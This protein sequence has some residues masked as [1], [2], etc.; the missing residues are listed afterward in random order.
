M[1]SPRY[2][3]EISHPGLKKFKRIT[4]P[5]P[6]AVERQAHMEYARWEETWA[7]QQV[8][9]RKKADAEHARASVRQ[10]REAERA[11]K[12]ARKQEAEDA[13]EAA[14][15][16]RQVIEGILQHTLAIDDRVDF[17]S[18]KDRAPFAQHPPI[19]PAAIPVS[20]APQIEYR[21][22][23]P[24]PLSAFA[25]VVEFLSPKTRLRRESLEQAAAASLRA[26]DEQIY[27]SALA[28]WQQMADG[29]SRENAKRKASFDSARA[30]HETRR[31][32][33]IANQEET[34]RQVDALRVAYHALD[35]GAVEQYCDLVLSASVYPDEFPKT[36]ILRYA[37]DAR[38]LVVE[39]Q[40]PPPEALPA[41]K[42]V[43]Y[44]VSSDTF[45]EANISSAESRK[46]YDGAVYQ[47]I[48]RT[49]HELFEA[50]VV[51]AL[52]AIAL[53][54]V[55]ETI[56]RSTGRE[57]RPCI[58]TIH[59]QRNEFLA[60]N[61]AE[62]NP[63]ACFRKLKGVGSA[64]LVELAP[65]APLVHLPRDDARYIE[66]REV[67]AGVNGGSNL[68]AMNWEDFEH[69]VRELF[70]REFASAGAEVR[71]T[72]AS[73]DGGVDAV[74]LD[75]DPIRGGKFVIQAK[76]YTNLVPVAAV[77]ELWGTMS[78][79]RA[80]KGILVTTATFGPDAY[81][82]AKDKPMTLLDG[83]NLLYLLEKHGTRAFIDLKAAKALAS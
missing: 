65:V 69:L 72:R 23:V 33:Y 38:T 30:A 31:G 66:A 18:L 4:G 82:F 68:A 61:L 32:Q 24:S 20:A 16:A 83:S 10:A 29:V 6:S 48:L 5:H 59:V 9:A 28:T 63:K 14:K 11:Y 64:E 41:L 70:E 77:R 39:Y 50:D 7:K 26:E 57:V 55:V 25:K 56:D 67:I 49:L 36:A 73:R 17:E 75:P 62:V 21:H 1:A 76:R 37:A 3:I 44:V 13:T 52:D 40:L 54:A 15:Q 71:V 78:H 45:E 27:R 80:A 60:I 81:E 79:E 12:A 74:V 43:K 2:C 35:A 19:P 58:A 51:N 34:N 46:L 8:A 47:I 22:Y 42:A 53:N